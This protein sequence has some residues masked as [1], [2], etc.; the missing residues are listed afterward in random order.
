MLSGGKSKV[1]RRATSNGRDSWVAYNIIGGG[2]A[3][4][5]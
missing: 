4:Q 3:L 5:P 1:T 2:S